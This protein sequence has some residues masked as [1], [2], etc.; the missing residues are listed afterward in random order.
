[1]KDDEITERVI[2][3]AIEVHRTLGPGLLESA[4]EICLCHEL[5]LQG[6]KFERQVHLP[7]VYKGVK[8]DAS[9]RIDIIV[10]GRIILE[11]KAVDSILPIHTAQLLSYLKLTNLQKGLILNF[12]AEILIKGLKRV[13]LTPPKL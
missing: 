9:Y 8:L 4:Y 6:L 3:A 10:E 1:M 7:V 13:S 5:Q 12:K 11:L 2:G